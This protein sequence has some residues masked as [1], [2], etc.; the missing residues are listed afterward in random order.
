[1]QGEKCILAGYSKLTQ[2]L[3]KFTYFRGQVWKIRHRVYG[4]KCTLMLF[5]ITDTC[6]M[7]LLS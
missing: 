3:N 2:T 6:D 1:M 7:C 5:V 4:L